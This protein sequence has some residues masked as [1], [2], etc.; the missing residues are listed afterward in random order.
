MK[1]LA[2]ISGVGLG[3]ALLVGAGFAEETAIVPNTPEAARAIEQLRSA[4]LA[5]IGNSHSYSDADNSLD[6]YYARKAREVDQLLTELEDGQPISREKMER[7]LNTD[8]AQTYAP[9]Y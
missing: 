1:P 2:I 3:I 9:N 5:D 6:H 7:A 4:K 8:H